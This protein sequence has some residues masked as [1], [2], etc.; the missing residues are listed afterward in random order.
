[1]GEQHTLTTERENALLSELIRQFGK[2]DAEMFMLAPEKYLHRFDAETTKAY[3]A[4]IN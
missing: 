3:K 4:L 1:M 2:K